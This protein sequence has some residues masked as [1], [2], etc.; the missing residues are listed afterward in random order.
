MSF[1]YNSQNPEQAS[2]NMIKEVYA[3]NFESEM[4]KICKLIEIYNYVAL[5]TEFPGFPNIGKG[6]SQREIY[7]NSIKANVDNLKLIQVG[8]TLC[9]QNGNYPK[10]TASWQFNFKF[11]LK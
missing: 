7:Y 2:E 3:D 8:I 4:K 9:D 10:E 11:D 5:D 6:L 1:Q